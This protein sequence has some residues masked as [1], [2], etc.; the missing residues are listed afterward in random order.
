[1]KVKVASHATLSNIRRGSTERCKANHLDPSKLIVSVRS[2]DV[3]LS[4]N[5][6]ASAFDAHDLRDAVFDYVEH[7]DNKVVKTACNV[8]LSVQTFLCHLLSAWLDVLDASEAAVVV[9]VV[10]VQRAS[11]QAKS[12]REYLCILPILF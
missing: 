8:A 10:S 11:I 9:V 1:M 7:L 4:D 5:L 2:G 3:R 6:L 12:E